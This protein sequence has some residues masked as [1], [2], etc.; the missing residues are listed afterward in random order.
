MNRSASRQVLLCAVLA[1]VVTAMAVPAV[2]FD[3]P[4]TPDGTVRAVS[5]ALADRHPEVLWQA[6]PPEL[7]DRHH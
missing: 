3:I 5:E 1:G 2:S 6:L 7:P 4:N